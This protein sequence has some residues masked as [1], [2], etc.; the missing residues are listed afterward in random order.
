MQIRRFHAFPVVVLFT[1][2]LFCG[3]RVSV[4]QDSDF[5]L[6]LHANS[7][8]ATTEIGLSPYPGATPYKEPGNSSST[9]DLGF[10]FGDTHFRVLGA[11]FMTADS[12]ARV[13]AFYRKPLS[14]YGEVL[15]CNHGQPVGT[16]AVV[17]GG[18]TCSDEKENHLDVNGHGIPSGGHE[19]R[20]GS[21]H[22]FRIVWIDESDP[23]STR[24][25]LVYI[26]LPKDSDK[27]ER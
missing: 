10:T 6:E 27:A 9:V 24:F 13:L 12:P 16:L 3:G 14:R 15:E 11:S 5:K 21:S 19:L 7:H 20:A 2:I 18:V 26:E 17:H 25:G 23:R 4:A 8:P 22:Q 1:A